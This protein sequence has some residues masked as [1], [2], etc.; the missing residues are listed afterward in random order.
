M[1]NSSIGLAAIAIAAASGMCMAQQSSGS[2]TAKRVDCSAVTQA[3]T[4]H[5]TMDHA[6]HQAALTECAPSAVPTL[7]GQ[8]AYG[9]IGEVVRMLEADPATDW[10]KVNIEAL[11]E[12]LI[13]MDDVTMQAVAV[14]R[15]VPG[16]VEI[17]VTGTGRTIAAIRRMTMNHTTMLDQ[18]ASYHASATEIPNGARLT[19]TAKHADDANAT[20]RIRGLGFAGIMTEGE[21]HAAHH[22]ALARGEPVH[23]R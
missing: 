15:S 12:H 11:R 22:L 8:A 16:G 19:I 21:H 5:A 13:D 20:A 18:G 14:Q 1:R 6:S 10:S 2:A 4:D 9:A 7:P 17:D 3:T 23:G